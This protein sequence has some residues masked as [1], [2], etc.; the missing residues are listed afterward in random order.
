MV[1]TDSI[2]KHTIAK[3]IIK[4]AN[5][6]NIMPQPKLLRLN[7]HSRNQPK[8]RLSPV[9]KAISIHGYFPD[10]PSPFGYLDWLGHFV[11][12]GQ[13][14]VVPTQDNAPPAC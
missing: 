11:D 7:N 6:Q 1:I 13:W 8:P 3:Q 12:Y 2:A 5:E 4:N 9:L 10:Q 14:V